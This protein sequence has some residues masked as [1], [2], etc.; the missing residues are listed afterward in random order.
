MRHIAGCEL[1]A[2]SMAE[3][4][5]LSVLASDQGLLSLSRACSKLGSEMGFRDAPDSQAQSYP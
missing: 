5:E 3:G 4:P 1:A 2:E